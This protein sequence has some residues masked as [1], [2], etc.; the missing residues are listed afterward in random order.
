[1]IDIMHLRP[2]LLRGDDED[3]YT[4]DLDIILTL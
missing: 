4:W 3:Y 1:M 2:I